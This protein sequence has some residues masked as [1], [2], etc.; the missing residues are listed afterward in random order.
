MAYLEDDRS[1]YFSE[2]IELGMAKWYDADKHNLNAWSNRFK[3]ILR[4][5]TKAAV[6]QAKA[7]AL[8]SSGTDGMRHGDCRTA[9]S[10]RDT[11]MGMCV[12]SKGIG[13]QAQAR[14]R[15]ILDADPGGSSGDMFYLG[16][17]GALVDRDSVPDAS[18]AYYLGQ[19]FYSTVAGDDQM[20][21]WSQPH[22]LEL[23]LTTNSD[24]AENR[25]VSNFHAYTWEG[26]LFRESETFLRKDLPS[27]TTSDAYLENDSDWP[28][29]VVPEDGSLV[30]ISARVN[31]AI[32]AGSVTLKAKINGS[33]TTLNLALSTVGQDGYVTQ[34]KDLE[35][36]SAGDRLGL[37]FETTSDFAPS[38]SL[39]LAVTPWYTVLA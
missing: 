33:P 38:G 28:E 6:T 20:W 35:S 8:D 13:Y 2:E 16:E 27:N 23:D 32:T 34:A 11:T 39:D 15:G 25:L 7:L 12:A 37:Q 21:V 5:A 17:D 4:T 19:Q 3:S 26:N 30:A 22:F 24:T 9:Q 36:L 14:A 31:A 10:P 29:I 1:H 18:K